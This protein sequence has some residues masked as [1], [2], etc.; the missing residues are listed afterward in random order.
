M[1]KTKLPIE[2]LRSLSKNNL[3]LAS[4]VKK[5]SE[6]NH[7]SCLRM[8]LSPATQAP[9]QHQFDADG[10]SARRGRAPV[11]DSLCFSSLGVKG[12]HDGKRGIR[13]KDSTKCN[14]SHSQLSWQSPL[15]LLTS[16][17]TMRRASSCIRGATCSLPYWHLP[18]GLK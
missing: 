15:M 1:S 3:L 18:T 6:R 4:Q 2:I 10:Y 14:M 16:L 5:P 9:N 12:V 7:L 8:V 13:A 11:S 17:G